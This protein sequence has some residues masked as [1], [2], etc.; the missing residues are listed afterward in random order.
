MRQLVCV[1]DDLVLTVLPDHPRRLEANPRGKLSQME[2][3]K[4]QGLESEGIRYL[5]YTLSDYLA[6]FSLLSALEY[7]RLYRR[8]IRIR[9]LPM[10]HASKKVCKKQQT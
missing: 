2:V 5:W 8:S 10:K 6:R 9:S 1:N 7:I 4:C 3:R